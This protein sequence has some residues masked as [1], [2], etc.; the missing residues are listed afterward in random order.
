MS[1]LLTQKPSIKGKA[2]SGHLNATFGLSGDWFRDTADSKYLAFDGCFISFYCLHLTA[3]PLTLKDEVKKPVPPRWDPASLS[4]FIRPYG[5]HIITGMAVG[6]Q[7]SSVSDKNLP[8]L[9]PLLRASPSFVQKE[10]E[11]SSLTVF[12][13]SSGQ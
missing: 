7:D 11:M 1:E 6:G 3:S 2:P 12:P 10:E 13:I 4:R 9:F 5:T 8:R